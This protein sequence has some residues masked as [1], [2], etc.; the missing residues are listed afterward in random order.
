MAFWRVGALCHETVKAHRKMRVPTKTL[1]EP[2]FHTEI[3][4]FPAY[5][6]APNNILLMNYGM[7]WNWKG[8]A[9]CRGHRANGS[10]T[11][12]TLCSVLRT[13][14]SVVCAYDK[15]Q[16]GLLVTW[17]PQQ[18]LHSLHELSFLVK[19]ELGLNG[20]RYQGNVLECS[21]PR[22]NTCFLLLLCPSFVTSPAPNS[23]TSGSDIIICSENAHGTHENRTTSRK[24]WQSHYSAIARRRDNKTDTSHVWGKFAE[25][26]GLTPRFA[27][28]RL[29]LP[30]PT[31]SK[32][33]Q[34]LLFR[35]GNW[36]LENGNSLPLMP[37]LSVHT[38][39][40]PS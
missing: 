14:R 32:L 9:E 38:S 40:R 39:P 25:G 7:L 4:C 37:C 34:Y 15:G 30:L 17:E 1:Q 8:K 6:L 5:F 21:D 33:P 23:T 3:L 20:V 36:T 11:L 16:Y 27:L 29:T 13:R 10:M 24:I 28:R 2:L 19:S 35:W 26:S 31:P 12:P 22:G 18:C